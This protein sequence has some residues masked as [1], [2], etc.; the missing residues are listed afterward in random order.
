MFPILPIDK[1]RELRACRIC[2]RPFTEEEM[3]DS[4]QTVISR[5][6]NEY[7]HSGCYRRYWDHL[8]KTTPTAA[9]IDWRTHR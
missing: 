3:G 8:M 6:E 5:R 1:A 2:A 4:S 9:D 7:A